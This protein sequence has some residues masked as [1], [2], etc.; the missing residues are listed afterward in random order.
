M[1]VDSTAPS[2]AVAMTLAAL[3]ATGA[4]PRPSGEGVT[5][6]KLRIASGIE[7]QLSDP[8][9]ATQGT[10]QLAWLA[11]SPDNANMAYIAKD[12][13]GSNAFAV[14]VRGTVSNAVDTLEDL[15]VGTVVPFTAG[16]PSPVSV[17][18]GAMTAL[19]QVTG[20]TDG[21]PGAGS[22][23]ARALSLLLADA[24]PQATVTVIGHSLGGCIATM[25]ALYLRDQSWGSLAPQFGV[26]TFAAPTAGLQDFADRFNSVRWNVNQAYVNTYD[27]VPR[28]WA[29]LDAA[30]QWYPAPPGPAAPDDVKD[31]LLREI[32]ALPGP[33]VY[34]QPDNATSPLNA[35]Y[36]QYD[37]ALVKT[38]TED[39][40]AQVAY[41][42]ANSTYLALL[43]TP[44]LPT[45]PVVT[46]ISPNVG[47][48]GTTT[49]TVTGRGFGSDSVVD[50][51]PVPCTNTVIVTD[52]EIVST[53]PEGFGVVDVRVTGALGTSPAVATGQFAYGGPQPVLVTGVSPD[54]GKA[55]QQVTITGAGF[56]E[57]P[58]VYFGKNLAAASF[59]SPTEISATA[60][61]TG[62]LQ[63]R[64]ADVRVLVNGYLSPAVPVDEFTYPSP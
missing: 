5:E 25:L 23:L 52:T 46:A 45:G 20:M 50:F 2:A 16:G 40:L 44:Q 24:P 31:F 56:A 41:Q 12:T 36:H 30:K 60:P 28:A 4:T 29:D 51:G 39:F 13:S 62:P 61:S 33:N 38:S 18:K 15:D 63:S 37:P 53:P 48:A 43:Q 22:S 26:I 34:V 1:T 3:A 35:D 11:V 8:A 9:L 32:E 59:V 21:S 55:G 6:Q 19:T 14:V 17:S 54:S 10:W 7:R 57:H 64:T 42:H 47:A 58:V 27:L 49:V